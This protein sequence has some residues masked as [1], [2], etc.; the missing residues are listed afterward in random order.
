MT[1]RERREASLPRDPATQ[2][3]DEAVSTSP[4]DDVRGRAVEETA[5]ARAA[6]AAEEN[7]APPENAGRTDRGDMKTTI[8]PDVAALSA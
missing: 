1:P 7:E 6:E 8:L 4:A 2:N 3:A 5:R